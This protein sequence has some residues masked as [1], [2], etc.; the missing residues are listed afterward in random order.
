MDR[1]TAVFNTQVR[2]YVLLRMDLSWAAGYN[3]FIVGGRGAGFPCSPLAGGCV[4][5][6]PLSMPGSQI[7][8]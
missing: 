6:E 8:R 5:A 2:K 4:H 3:R 1:E 7:G